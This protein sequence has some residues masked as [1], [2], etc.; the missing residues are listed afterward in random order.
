MLPGGERPD[1]IE[2]DKKVFKNAIMSE[3]VQKN[4]DFGDRGLKK[5]S[6][7]KF[8]K[9]L[10]YY[11]DINPKIVWSDDGRSE[12]GRWIYY[13]TVEPEKNEQEKELVLNF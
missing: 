4:P 7:T 9:W 6:N 13:S 11:S 10:R 1:V 12:A 5:I 8:Y 3:F 2:Y